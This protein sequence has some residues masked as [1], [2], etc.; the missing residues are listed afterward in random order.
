MPSDYLPVILGE[1]SSEGG[2]F[3]D[4]TD[5]QDTMSLLMRY[6]N[7]IAHDFEHETVHFGYL[8][9]PADDGI[10]GREW[11]RGYLR[12][13]RL[14]GEGWKQMIQHENEGLLLTIPIVAGEVDPAWPKE[15]LTEEKA[16]EL[17]QHLF[18]AA[19][20]AYQYFKPDRAAYAQIATRTQQQR[21]Q[22]HGRRDPKIGRND[23]CPCGSGSKFKK[24][25]GGPGLGADH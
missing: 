18:A 25:C 8:E 23:A 15:P 1:Q 24:C 12:G 9:E 2:A 22:P 10:P 16:E 5:A 20:R 21:S 7:A 14:S 19:A 17:Q 4:L 13:M 3:R 11:A 6:W